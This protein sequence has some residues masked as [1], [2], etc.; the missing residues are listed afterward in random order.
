MTCLHTAPVASSECPWATRFNFDLKHVIYTV[1]FAKMS[2]TG[3]SD[4][5][6]QV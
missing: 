6:A 2:A 5:T 3:N 4:A 1:F